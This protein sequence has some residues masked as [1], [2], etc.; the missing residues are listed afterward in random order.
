VASTGTAGWA[1]ATSA[2]G[3]MTGGGGVVAAGA[4]G[5]AAAGTAARAG[6]TAVVTTAGLGGLAGAGTA[7]GLGDRAGVGG[8]ERSRVD[9]LDEGGIAGSA[10]LTVIGPGLAGDTGLATDAGIAE[11]AAGQVDGLG[12]GTTDVEWET[13]PAPRSD[14]ITIRGAVGDGAV[15]DGADSTGRSIV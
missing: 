1:F 15:G 8:A 7:V 14:V 12:D 11:P 10:T 13:A 2:A 9:A 4:A 6:T 3:T 5:A